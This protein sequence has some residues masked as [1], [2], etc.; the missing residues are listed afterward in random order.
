[1]KGV[2]VLMYSPIYNITYIAWVGF[3]SGPDPI[4]PFSDS[5]AWMNQTEAPAKTLAEKTRA[6]AEQHGKAFAKSSMGSF[7]VN[8]KNASRKNSLAEFAL[9]VVTKECCIGKR[10]S[11]Y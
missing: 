1:M 7:G 10:V 8:V 6:F 4:T 2:V 9:G 5:P 11:F 3:Q